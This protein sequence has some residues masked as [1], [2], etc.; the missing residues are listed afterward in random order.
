M[1][2]LYA[3]KRHF[4]SICDLHAWMEPIMKMLSPS[5]LPAVKAGEGGCDVTARDLKS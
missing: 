3:I 4:I 2:W 5:F 1:L